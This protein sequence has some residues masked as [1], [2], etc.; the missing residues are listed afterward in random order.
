MLNTVCIF[1]ISFLLGGYAQGSEYTIIPEQVRVVL[2]STNLCDKKKAF[3]YAFLN[4]D[5]IILLLNW[6]KKKYYN[7]VLGAA[8]NIPYEVLIRV[9]TFLNATQTNT[10]NFC[11]YLDQPS[12]DLIKDRKIMFS[13]FT[14]QQN[15]EDSFCLNVSLSNPINEQGHREKIDAVF[16]ALQKNEFL[17]AN[18][19]LRHTE[20]R[21]IIKNNNGDITHFSLQFF[22][23]NDFIKNNQAPLRLFSKSPCHYRSFDNNSESRYPHVFENKVFSDAIRSFHMSGNFVFAELMDEHTVGGGDYDLEFHAPNFPVATNHRIVIFD[24]TSNNY[25]DEN[26]IQKIKLPTFSEDNYPNKDLK[27]PFLLARFDIVDIIKNNTLILSDKLTGRLLCFALSNNDYVT[28]TKG[29]SGHSDFFI[30]QP[31]VMPVLENNSG[32]QVKKNGDRKNCII[33]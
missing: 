29:E 25:D 10:F 26:A 30:K 27:E 19:H 5:Q 33:F 31:K 12:V 32:W 2:P 15:G 8:T 28:F 11:G 16:L 14:V 6:E 24:S 4:A 17:P 1:I 20:M 3:K 21:K 18:V 23:R 13:D 9:F 22:A 7:S